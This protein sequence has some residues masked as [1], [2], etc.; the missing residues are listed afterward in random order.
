MCERAVSEWKDLLSDIFDFALILTDQS[1]EIIVK[2]AC[3]V[4]YTVQHFINL[5]KREKLLA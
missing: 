3:K 1:R 2:S 5:A 4:L